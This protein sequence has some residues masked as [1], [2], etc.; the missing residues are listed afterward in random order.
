MRTEYTTID[1]TDFLPD[2]PWHDEPDKISWTDEAS[3]L[4]CLIVRTEGH[5]ALCGY[6]GVPP[7]HPLH[8]VDYSD[9]YDHKNEMLNAAN[10]AAHCGLTYSAPCSPSKD[11]DESRGICHI[12]AP[13]ETDDI[14]WLGF[15]CVHSYDTAP[16]R[17]DTYSDPSAKYRTVAYVTA[18]CEAMARVLQP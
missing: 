12:P 7:E 13:G 3:G 1:K 16:G 6:V 11:G 8:G 4:P 9:A 14:W 2:G 5:G 10:D 17:N 18:C 15:D